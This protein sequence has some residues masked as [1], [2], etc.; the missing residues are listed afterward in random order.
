MHISIAS[1][2]YE[3]GFLMSRISFSRNSYHLVSLS[4][5]F[6][7]NFTDMHLLNYLEKKVNIFMLL[8]V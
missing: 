5:F 3:K 1:I 6:S 2:G 8:K 7:H 4:G